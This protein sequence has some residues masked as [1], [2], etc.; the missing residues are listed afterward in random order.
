MVKICYVLPSFLARKWNDLQTSVCVPTSNFT[1][2]YKYQINFVS[3]LID[4][5]EREISV[6]IICAI[7]A[8][9]RVLKMQGRK[10]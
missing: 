4:R 10:L 2:S 3:V 6:E 5:C 8:N 7:W 9:H 1:S